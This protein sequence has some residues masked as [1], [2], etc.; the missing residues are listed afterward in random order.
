MSETA[1][2]EVTRQQVG[3][4]KSVLGLPQCAPNISG[5]V[6][7][8]TKPF[9]DDLYAM[10]LK[11]YLRLQQQD[12]S[13]WSK[14][15]LL[16]HLRGSWFSPYIKH[17]IGVKEEVGMAWGPVSRKHVDIVVDHYSLRKL[18]DKLYSLDLPALRRVTKFAVAPHVNE[19][20]ES[21]VCFG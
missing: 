3:M 6:L 19:S 15:A 17:I 9:K 20:E 14:D 16:D 8:G 13:R 5:D 7:L 4:S 2:D 11:F 10:Q 18:N 21:Q 12:E 1:M